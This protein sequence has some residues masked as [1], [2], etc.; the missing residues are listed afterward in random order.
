M[1]GKILLQ[2]SNKK[3]R[4]EQ[5]IKLLIFLALLFI[6]IIVTI[7]YFYKKPYFIFDNLSNIILG[8]LIVLPVSIY[9]FKKY[10]YT[11]QRWSISNDGFTPTRRYVYAISGFKKTMMFY[12]WN[13]FDYI[14]LYKDTRYTKN[15]DKWITFILKIGAHQYIGFTIVLNLDDKTLEK[16]FSII[17]IDKYKIKIFSNAE[18]FTEWIHSNDIRLHSIWE[19]TCSETEI[20][21]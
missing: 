16:L 20:H 5:R 14:T 13:Q 7:Y 4:K 19:D 15:A 2:E 17:N 9:L 6:L 10:V 11:R 18:E 3:Y 8:Y 1:V 21:F 12:S